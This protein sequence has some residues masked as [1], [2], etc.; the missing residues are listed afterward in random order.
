MKNKKRDIRVAYHEAGHAV[1]GYHLFGLRRIKKITI[2]PEPKKNT[3]GHVR[4]TLIMK[5]DD[6]E[7]ETSP[8][9]EGKIMREIMECLAGHI[10]EKKIAGRANN[11]GASHDFE[12]A[13]GL[14]QRLDC[15]WDEKVSNHLWSYLY[16]RTELLVK[17]KWN[18]I[19][20]TA[21]KLLKNKTLSREDFY[22]I[23]DEERIQYFKKL[24]NKKQLRNKNNR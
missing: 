12:Q 10:A 7:T 21:K 13:F 23:T 19:V 17:R 6:Y 2:I 11:G 20:L 16:R 9:F 8:A 1:V 15:G 14:I 24:E 3:L 22:E 5:R 18:L 4:N